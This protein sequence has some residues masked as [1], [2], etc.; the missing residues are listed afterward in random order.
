MRFY[1]ATRFIFPRSYRLR[2][3]AVCFGA[4]HVPLAVFC[5][6]QMS[7]GGWDW[8][9]FSALLV[10]TLMG[11]GIAI[12]ALAALLA[13]IENAIGLLKGLQAGL[14]ISMVPAGGDDLVGE[15]LTAVA[16][17]SAENARRIDRLKA[18]AEIDLLTGVRNR[19]GFLDALPK[20]LRRDQPSVVALI[21]LDH[22]KTVNDRF[23]HED[24][25]HILA[26][27]AGRLERGVRRSDICARWGG[28][29]F[30]VLLPDTDIDAAHRVMERLRLSLTADPISI[31]DFTLTFS[32]GLAG[33][34]DLAA[35][36]TALREADTA[37][38]QAKAAGRNMVLRYEETTP[39]E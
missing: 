30:A 35:L 16:T 25:D 5:I 31:G 6:T 10:A 39:Y 22:F 27:F 18:A 9:L 33:A 11:T 23:G 12:G 15:L 19:R 32:C 3:F 20:L 8:R 26:T 4:V 17:A 29:E 28:E 1:R 24:G 34:I 14:P 7:F 2:I 38:Y 13:P 36:N 21:D 37:L